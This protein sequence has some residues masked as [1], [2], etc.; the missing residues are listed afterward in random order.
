ML[1]SDRT[2]NGRRLRPAAVTCAAVV[3]VLAGTFA[4]AAP[5][6]A[7]RPL[8]TPT[9]SYSYTSD[10]GEYIGGGGSGSFTTPEYSF[11]LSGDSRGVNIGIDKDLWQQWSIALEPDAGQQLT[12]GQS[13]G[14]NMDSDSARVYVSGNGRGCSDDST[15][16]G[17]FTVTALQTDRRTGE[18][19][20]FGA[21]FV[22]N[23][24]DSF[25]ALR[26]SVH[27][28]TS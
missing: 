22:Q 2:K 24:D 1:S 5:A 26:G 27:Y 18:I 12:V 20:E 28:K 14:D 4:A 9:G 21:D 25:L 6:Q 11:H 15:T 16:M 3:S 7:A 17:Y 23:C 19:T 8:P 13:Y 10:P